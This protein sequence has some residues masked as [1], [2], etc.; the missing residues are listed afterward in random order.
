MY[1]CVSVCLS[2]CL[3]VCL[4]VCLC[5]SFC[6]ALS[7]ESLDPGSSFLVCRYIFKK[8]SIKIDVYG[9]KSQEQNVIV[10]AR[11]NTADPIQA[12]QHPGCHP[13]TAQPDSPPA[14]QTISLVD[15]KDCLPSRQPAAFKPGIVRQPSS[16]TQQ[17]LS[18]SSTSS[19]QASAATRQSSSPA[20]SQ[21]CRQ[22]RL[23]SNLTT[24]SLQT[25]HS[26]TTFQPDTAIS[27][28]L[29]SENG[30]QSR[31]ERSYRK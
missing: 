18:Q 28:S 19:L 27:K 26:Q 8:S 21:P 1:V 24:S 12:H 14:R 2:V 29:P 9:S 10:P 7:F 15:S 5:L 4:S 25:R 3:C 30:M 13:G 20:H 16:L 17:S 6:N 31:A 11:T 23:P 22:S